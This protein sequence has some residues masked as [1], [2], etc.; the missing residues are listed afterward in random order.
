MAYRPNKQNQEILIKAWDLVQ[1]VPYKVT[2]RWLFYKLLP[3]EFYGHKDDYKNKFIPLMSKA[4]KRFYNEWKPD[5]LTDDTRLPVIRGTGFLSVEYWLNVLIEEGII[6][7]LDKWHK[8]DYYIEIWFEAR[9]MISQFEYYTKHITLRPMGGQPS[10]PL[11]WEIAKYLENLI[12]PDNIVILYFGDL[13]EAGELISD[14]VERDVRSWCNVDFEFIRCG[15]TNEQVKKY[16][17]PENPEK[18]NQFQWVGLSDLGAR[19][20]I[21]NAITPFVNHDLILRIEES[22]RNAEKQ[23]KEV[24]QSL[25]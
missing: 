2:A 24:L 17:L 23:V 3:E 4:R 18:P 15:L 7:K 25:K 1:S 13:D 19:E 8:Q 6:C 9:G 21:Q 20:I 16:K 12:N 11:K 10:I 22:E 5:T 14:V